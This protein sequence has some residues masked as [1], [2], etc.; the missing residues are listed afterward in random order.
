MMTR[1]LVPA[2]AMALALGCQRN[3]RGPRGEGGVTPSPSPTLAQSRMDGG[4]PTVVLLPDG[5]DEVRIRVELAMTPGE[6]QRG[7]MFRTAM[8]PDAGMLFLF[9][10]DEV[11]T[12]W[13]KN[14]L[15]PLDMVFIGSD[16]RVVG[17]VERA[18]PQTLTGRSVNKVSRHVLEL[19]GGLAAAR[20]I[21]PGTRVRYLN[22][23]GL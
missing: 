20:G 3:P 4:E 14:T 17:V 2:L 5:R 23:P 7:L 18:E 10:H 16:G 6:Q 8:A 12:F 19:V 22:V 11:H 13:M 21:G 15:I 1:S 9:D